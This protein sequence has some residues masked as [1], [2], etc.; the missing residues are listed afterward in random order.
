[1]DLVSHGAIWIVF[2]SVDPFAADGFGTNGDLDGCVV[3]GVHGSPIRIRF[4]A[5]VAEYFQPII[6]KYGIP[7]SDGSSFQLL[8]VGPIHCFL[9]GYRIRDEGYFLII[10]GEIG[11]INMGHRGKQCF[12]GARRITPF[13]MSIVDGF[14]VLGSSSLADETS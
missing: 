1:V 14:T 4:Q 7:F 3:F 2:C 6:F 8:S 9:I 10:L 13:S 12:S 5:A 11:G